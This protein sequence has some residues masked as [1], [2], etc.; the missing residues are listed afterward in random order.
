MKVQKILNTIPNQFAQKPEII[1]GIRNKT[2]SAGVSD[3][4]KPAGVLVKEKIKNLAEKTGEIVSD[5]GKFVL[6]FMQEIGL[7]IVGALF[8]L[9][10][11]IT[12]IPFFER[13]SSRFDLKE[14]MNKTI[15]LDESDGGKEITK[16]EEV[17][18]YDAVE[19][20]N[21]EYPGFNWIFNFDSVRMSETTKDFVFL[22]TKPESDGGIKITDKEKRQ[23][24]ELKTQK[25][26]EQKE[27]KKINKESKKKRLR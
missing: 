23:F 9:Y 22:A 7:Q 3:K 4:F 8:S 2:F 25:L 13:L 26:H 11:A 24:E 6:N 21:K 14:E 10:C 17:A 19:F 27:L 15:Q 20:F 12:V 1:E 5:V 16:E 18:F